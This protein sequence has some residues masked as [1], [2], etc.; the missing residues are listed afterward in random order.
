MLRPQAQSKG[1]APREDN[2]LHLKPLGKP[3]AQTVKYPL[4]Q[5]TA[6]LKKTGQS[7]SWIKSKQTIRNQNPRSQ[8]TFGEGPYDW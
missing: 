1:Q 4:L 2:N 6:K 8:F 3:E 5:G 7:Q